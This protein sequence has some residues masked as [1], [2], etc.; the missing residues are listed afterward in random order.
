[1][2]EIA[3]TSQQGVLLKGT[4]SWTIDQVAGIWNTLTPH[5]NGNVAIDAQGIERMDSAGLQI[6]LMAKKHCAE[7]GHVCKVLNHSLPVLKI[8]DL[9]G[10]LASARD[11]VRISSQDRAA[12][13]LTYSRNR[14]TIFGS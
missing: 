13:D 2:L 3:Q 14:F 6:L 7:N 4:G 12:L 5:L 1:M 11:Q 9:A 8:M 10:V